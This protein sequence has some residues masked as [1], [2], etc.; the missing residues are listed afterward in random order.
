MA[1]KTIKSPMPGTFYRR[2]DPESDT[3]VSE[4]DEVSPGDT[5][6]LIEVMKSFHEVKAE[7]GGTISRILV[8]DEDPVGAGQ[9]LVELE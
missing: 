4:G 1:E 9:D 3:Y 7:E 6:G 5:V 8:E 2:P